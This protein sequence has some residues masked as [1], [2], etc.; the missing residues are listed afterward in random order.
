MQR[1]LM[2][3]TV[4]VPC[5]LWVSGSGEKASSSEVGQLYGSC[6]LKT[7][8]FTLEGLLLSE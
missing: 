1:F 7:V 3:V 6:L 4:K 2:R 5:A 8:L